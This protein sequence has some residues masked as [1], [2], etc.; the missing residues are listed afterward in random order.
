MVNP[1]MAESIW[2]LMK[3]TIQKQMPNH[4]PRHRRSRG[5]LTLT[6]TRLRKWRKR[7][8]RKK[9]SKLLTEVMTMCNLKML[10]R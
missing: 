1:N 7:R 3:A 9:L 10:N 2:L 6:P 5:M 8:I 4:M